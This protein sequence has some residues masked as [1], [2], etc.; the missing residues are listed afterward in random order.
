MKR[1]LGGLALFAGIVIAA[2]AVLRVLATRSRGAR[3]AEPDVPFAERRAA[4]DPEALAE[5]TQGDRDRIGFDLGKLA[6]LEE[7]YHP[8]VQ[9]LTAIQLK[10]GEEG[11]TLLFVRKRD[12]ESISELA[13]DSPETMVDHFRELGILMSMN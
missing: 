12:L 9:Y 6:E 1:V 5:M 4:P 3:T 10:R 8:V 7:N 2:G 11:E 13:G